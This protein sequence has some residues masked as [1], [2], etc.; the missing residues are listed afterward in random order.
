ML[1]LSC[2]LMTKVHATISE[3]MAPAEDLAGGEVG[4]EAA[5][6]AKTKTK[7]AAKKKKKLTDRL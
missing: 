5:V 3:D 6:A 1:S 4:A 2:R 7:G